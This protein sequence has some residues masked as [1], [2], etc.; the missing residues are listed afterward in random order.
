[1]RRNPLEWAILIVSVAAIA[2]IGAYLLVDALGGPREPARV[3][4]EVQTAQATEGPL[5]W[6]APVIIRNEGG[7]GATGLLLEA[8]A[9][10]DGAEETSQ[11]TVDLLGPMS[12]AEVTV[13]FTGVPAGAVDI[14]VVAFE[15]P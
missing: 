8:T 12:E 15:V 3:V 1:M 6:T 10:V 13:G 2:G 7:E 9:T 11:L 5:G 14:R 4:A